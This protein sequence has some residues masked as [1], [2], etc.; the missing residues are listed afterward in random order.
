MSKLLA[1]AS[2]V[3]V[4]KG[5]RRDVGFISADECRGEFSRKRWSAAFWNAE[6]D[7]ES[8]ELFAHLT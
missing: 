4:P 2:L 8:K 3:E 6:M 7:G 5:S 1:L